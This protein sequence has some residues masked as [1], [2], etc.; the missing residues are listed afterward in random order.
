[1]QVPLPDY[2]LFQFPI[3]TTQNQKEQLV[4]VCTYVGGWLGVG[5]DRCGQCSY[6]VKAKDGEQMVN[7]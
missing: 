7:G 1:M 2:K 4:F 5:E 3:E 6:A